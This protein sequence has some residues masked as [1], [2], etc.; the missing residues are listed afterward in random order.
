MPD[1]F[2][3]ETRSRIMSSI[4]GVSKL[5]DRISREL[6]KQGLRYRRNQR[7][8]YGTPDF[9]IK[10][11]KIVIF[12]DSCYWHKCP[13]H[14]KKPKSNIE[15]WENKFRNN[16]ARDKRVTEF[17]ETNGWNVLRIWEH[18]FKEDFEGAIEKII[19][20]INKTKKDY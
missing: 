17:Y 10:K 7:R 16:V 13:I 11:Y 4:K 15:F 19:N 3:K 8:L 12:V 2:P 1:R 6:W 9:S 14:W 20:F 18:E 5:E